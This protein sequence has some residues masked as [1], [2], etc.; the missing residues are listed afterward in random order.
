M[1]SAALA[2]AAHAAVRSRVASRSGRAPS[3][4][5]VRAR[6]APTA[7]ISTSPLSDTPADAPSDPLAALQGALVHHAPTGDLVDL[8]ARLSETSPGKVTVVAFM[9]SFG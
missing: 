1:A 9:R 6:A 2:S 7:S 4:D 5:S 8:G 3:R